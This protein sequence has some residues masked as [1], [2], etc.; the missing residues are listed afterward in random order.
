MP[1]AGTNPFAVHLSA[2]LSAA[3]PPI[4]RP[5]PRRSSTRLNKLTARAA[6]PVPLRAFVRNHPRPAARPPAPTPSAL[7]GDLRRPRRRPSRPGGAAPRH[8]HRAAAAR[9]L[10]RLGG[11]SRASCRPSGRGPARRGHAACAM[12]LGSVVEHQHALVQRCP[13]VQSS[14]TSTP[15]CSAP[16]LKVGCAP[17]STSTL[18]ARARGE[19]G[20]GPG[21]AAGGGE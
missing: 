10:R 18:T 7:Y 21:R 20:R 2:T 8:A 19:G 16:G 12:S 11:T 15:S 13:W 9:A 17:G 5:P 1:S 3:P 6:P 4:P 14:S